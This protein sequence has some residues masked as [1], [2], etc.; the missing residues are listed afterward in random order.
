MQNAAQKKA[1][2]IVENS[3]DARRLELLRKLGIS[4]TPQPYRAV[5]SQSSAA[6]LPKTNPPAKIIPPASVAI[7]P[8]PLPVVPV[9]IAKE[10]VS[11]PV[12][13]VVAKEITPQK[14]I[15]A[16]IIPHYSE[17]YPRDSDEIIPRVAPSAKCDTK[18]KIVVSEIAI[19]ARM[20]SPSLIVENRELNEVRAAL[21]AI[22]VAT[23]L[24]PK[25]IEAAREIVTP[26][27]P[28]QC[29]V[30]KK[31]TPIVPPNTHAVRE[32]SASTAARVILSPNIS[33]IDIATLTK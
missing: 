28:W 31:Q 19:P 32:P 3:P 14:P 25:V 4:R 9:V 2:L 18:E 21:Q 15:A 11:P 10:I 16:A 12:V 33:A 7:I 22:T 30:E 5:A 6:I 13:P 23:S 27:V 29:R 24:A 17:E 1:V 26:E 20:E 8:K